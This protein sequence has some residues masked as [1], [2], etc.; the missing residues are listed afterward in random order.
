VPTGN[1]VPAILISTPFLI[2]E[3]IVYASLIAIMPRAGGDYVWQTRILGGP[4]GFVLAVTGWWFI[5][6]H[7]VPLYGTML[8][9]MVF[10]PLFAIAGAKDTAIWFSSAEG[11][12]WSSII[13]IVI[14]SIIIALGMRTY[15]R[16]QRWCFY[17]GALGLV[18]VFILLLVN[19]Q[20][21]FQTAFN[22][23]AT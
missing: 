22:S 6:W 9:Y 20:S 21:N 3:V 5:L 1:L 23:Q 11:T 7:W 17:G 18:I 15:A 16:I 4:I 10:T 13:T 2:F 8:S 14:V 12:F 19:S